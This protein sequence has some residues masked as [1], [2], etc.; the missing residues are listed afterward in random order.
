MGAALTGET[1]VVGAGVAVV[2]TGRASGTGSLDARIPDGAGVAVVTGPVHKQVVARARLDVAGVEGTGVAVL[3]GEGLS[4]DAL[5][6]RARIPDSA[7]IPV[8][9]FCSGVAVGAASRRV[10]GIHRA[11]IAVVA[12]DR[13]SPGAEAVEATLARGAGVAVVAFVIGV[14]VDAACRRVARVSGAGVAVVAALLRSRTGALLA[15]VRLRAGIAVVAGQAV[16]EAV[17]A[18]GVDVARV[19]GTRVSVVAVQGYPHA[20]PVHAAILGGACVP[21]VA[22]SCEAGMCAAFRWV[23][24]IHRAGVAIVAAR[25]RPGGALAVEAAVVAGAEVVVVAGGVIGDG[26]VAALALGGA[27]DRSAGPRVGALSGVGAGGGKVGG[28]LGVV[29]DLDDIG[30]LGGG[31]GGLAGG[32][33]HDDEHQ[34]CLP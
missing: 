31:D 5:T 26:V 6:E 1:E 9:A 32:C 20:D 15:T 33:E 7:G 14:A 24:G 3:A 17:Q 22:P 8:V 2:A 29:G 21:I 12:I 30:G 4:G 28:G 16:D 27:G 19:G 11:G 34:G 23:A 13:A 25:G 10:A 18:T